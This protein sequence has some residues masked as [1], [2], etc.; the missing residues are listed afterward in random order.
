MPSPCPQTFPMGISKSAHSNMNSLPYHSPLDPGDRF[1]ECPILFRD[2]IV[3]LTFIIQ[4]C[5]YLFCIFPFS[6]TS[7]YCSQDITLTSHLWLQFAFF[8]F[9]FFFSIWNAPGTM[10]GFENMN[11]LK[12]VLAEPKTQPDLI[13]WLDQKGTHC[14]N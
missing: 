11:G 13:G 4:K 6:F 10:L 9:S 1:P 2:I 14:A 3:K 7:A 8:F 12:V 5:H